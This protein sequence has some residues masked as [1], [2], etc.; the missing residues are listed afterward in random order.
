MHRSIDWYICYL[1]CALAGIPVVSASRDLPDEAAE[2][3]RFNEIVSLL[4]PVGVITDETDGYDKK[5]PGK[6]ILI[7]DLLLD[8]GCEGSPTYVGESTGN[9]LGYHFTGGST[10]ASKC[11]EISHGMA[12]HEILN[13]PKILP[14]YCKPPESVLQN[15]SVYWS[16]SAFGQINIAIAFQA[17]LVISYQGG[18]SADEVSNL[19]QKYKI[20]CI[21]VVP[22]V[23]RA[24]DPDACSSL[25]TVFTWGESLP[26]SVAAEWC[27]RVDLVDLLIA[28]EYWL[29]FYALI[30]DGAAGWSYSTV[31]SANI[32]LDKDNTVWISGPMVASRYVDPES[33]YGERFNG[34]SFCTNDTM[35]HDVATETYKYAGRSDDM[36]KVG[37]KFVDLRA[38]AETISESIDGEC[39]LVRDSVGDSMH[40]VFE[41]QSPM[42]VNKLVTMVQNHIPSVKPQNVHILSEVPRNP[43]TGKRDIQ[44]LIRRVSDIRITSREYRIPDESVPAG[45]LLAIPNPK[46][47]MWLVLVLSLLSMRGWNLV[48]ACGEFFYEVVSKCVLIELP[49]LPLIRFPFL[50]QGLR[51]LAEQSRWLKSSFYE[52]PGDALYLAL[53]LMIIGGHDHQILSPLVRVLALIG[54]FR[55]LKPDMDPAN[56]ISYTCI[57]ASVITVI[58][59]SLLCQW[60][61]ACMYAASNILCLSLIPSPLSAFAVGLGEVAAFTLLSDP[62]LELTSHALT[63]VALLSEWRRLVAFLIISYVNLPYDLSWTWQSWWKDVPSYASLILYYAKHTDKRLAKYTVYQPVQ[64]VIVSVY[65]FVTCCWDTHTESGYGSV[66]SYRKCSSGD[67]YYTCQEC[68]K[69]TAESE[70]A[71]DRYKKFSTRGWFC[72][73]CWWGDIVD[74]E[75]GYRYP[76]IGLWTSNWIYG[77]LR[78]MMFPSV[79]TPSPVSVKSWDQWS[80]EN[81]LSSTR[82]PSTDGIDDFSLDDVPSEQLEIARQCVSAFQAVGIDLSAD[83]SFGG[84]SSLLKVSVH[85]QLRSKLVGLSKISAMSLF[86]DSGD[87]FQFVDK[88]SKLTE[89]VGKSRID[90]TQGDGAGLYRIPLTNSSLWQNAPCDWLLKYK[91]REPWTDP[92]VRIQKAI[93]ALVKKHPALRARPIDDL[94]QVTPLMHAIALSPTRLKSPVLSAC[95][96]LWPRIHVRSFHESDPIPAQ[97]EY[98]DEGSF[99]KKSVLNRATKYRSSVAFIPPF[100]VVVYLPP[101]AKPVSAIYMHIRVTHLFADGYCVNAIASDLDYFLS[102]DDL[103][104]SCVRPLNGFR[105]LQDRLFRSLTLRGTP[106]SNNMSSMTEEVYRDKSI[107]RV[108]WLQHSTVNSLTQCA[109]YLGVPIEI[110]L[111]GIVMASLAEKL[112]WDRMPVQL[113]HALRDGI[114]ESGMMGFFSDYKDMGFFNTKCSYI[115]LFHQLSTRIRNRDWRVYNSSLYDHSVG[116]HAWDESVFPVSFNVLPHMRLPK[117]ARTENIET[118]WRAGPRFDQTDC[119]LIHVYMEETKLESEWAIR[120]HVNRRLFDC[121]WTVDYACRSFEKAL[122]NVLCEPTKP[123]ST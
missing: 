103:D 72:E 102:Q 70:G 88:V 100:D 92:E 45:K 58:A 108:L 98:G 2:L 121:Q 14:K 65:N 86:K 37:G 64:G 57:I 123:I 89:Q 54:D 107:V 19:V 8:E 60:E 12:V 61:M 113:M 49:I 119:R 15:S 24:L 48:Q 69:W 20:E 73:T 44:E 47:Y 42:N 68:R 18:A 7:Q 6:R 53:F 10:A 71:F 33:K 79:P 34:T 67:R 75:K 52:F 27:R 114:D 21:G 109:S 115:D 74:S 111:M 5:F 13:Y 96:E 112:G 101:Q 40:A 82:H 1:A 80:V 78:S 117:N 17:C 106:E 93:R 118:Y 120:L 62:N 99:S 55:V 36:Q 85:E 31:P 116:R 83:R 11:V 122:K 46:R 29:S 39:M 91:P 81:D 94:S 105:V 35:S 77:K 9:P 30:E 59:L 25:T 16:A 28:T 63:T 51:T 110:V 32:H 90:L 66:P 26:R 23:L 4:D 50:V 38:V 76:R 97:F 56:C 84:L 87:L 41:L 3:N 43:A 22:S 95:K 104:L